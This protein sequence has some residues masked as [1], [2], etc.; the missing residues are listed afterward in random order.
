VK[1]KA[2]FIALFLPSVSHAL[3]ITGAYANDG[4]D[5]IP[6][7][8][9][10]PH[11]VSYSSSTINRFWTGSTITPFTAQ[12]DLIHFQVIAYNNN[13]VDAGSVTVS[14][15]S[16]SCAGNT[17][18]VN[19]VQASSLTVTSLVGRPIRV[20]SA[21]YVQNLGMS[22]LPYGRSEYE[23]RQYPLDM[24]VP[25]TINV[26]HDCIPN[27]GTD[28]WTNR[29]M[30]NLY[31]PVAWIPNEEFA[32]VSTSSY[33]VFRSSSMAWDVDVWT[34]S[35]IPGGTCTGTF[36]IFEGGSL[37]TAMPVAMQVYPVQISTATGMNAFTFI[38]NSDLDK[39]IN[40]NNSPS[41]PVTGNFLAAR[42]AT[43]QLFK[44][45]GIQVEGDKPDVGTNDYWSLEYSSNIT[46]ATFTPALGYAN[47]P[48]V[49]SVNGIYVIGFYGGW[50]TVNWSTGSAVGPS[51]FCTNVS[52]WL[53]NCINAGVTCALYTPADEGSPALLATEVASMTWTL[54]NNA[55]CAV[56]GKTLS[57]LQTDNLPDVV[58]S[59]PYASWIASTSE[60]YDNFAPSS[61]TWQ[62]QASSIQA[63]NGFAGSNGLVLRYNASSIGSGA[64]YPYEE[65]GYVP[66][67]NFW[68]YWKKLCPNGN[69]SNTAY[70]FYEGNYWSNA[71]NGGGCGNG[72][73]GGGFGS[74]EMDIFNNIFYGNRHS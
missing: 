39:R 69:C 29:T 35:S 59:A 22:T 21:W 31:L 4:G 23:A 1:W 38:G 64:M 58:S 68:A 32:P 8:C 54:Q 26:N 2:L 73:L 12:G 74:N 36:S 16:M 55:R 10:Y 9:F 50:H 46:G 72:G 13:S 51:D 47:A 33:T 56:G 42:Q 17:G 37:S 66:Q 27:G 34:S 11:C 15:S 61:V 30:A 28:L 24:R 57:F 20:Y 62:V 14:M 65:E 70:M 40:G 43:A 60:G 6:R 49:G 41:L 18:I 7:D 45:N 5:K 53:A 67:A 19:T 48:G 52:S 44:E 25:C 63:G 3:N 71:D